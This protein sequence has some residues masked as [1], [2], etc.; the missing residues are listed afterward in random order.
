MLKM[1]ERE[2]AQKEFHAKNIQMMMYVE[3]QTTLKLQQKLYKYCE[4]NNLLNV[5]LKMSHNFIT[6]Q[7]KVIPRVSE[8][9]LNI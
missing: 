6:E 4:N 8:L 9:I 1:A 2:R 3:K 5:S 7:F